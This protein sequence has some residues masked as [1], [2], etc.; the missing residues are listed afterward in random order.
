MSANNF[1]YPDGYIYGKGCIDPNEKSLASLKLG[2]CLE[3]I[4]GKEGRVLEIGCGGGKFI[5]S[6]KKLR[7]ELKIFGCDIYLNII[8]ENIKYGDGLK[9]SIADGMSLPF[10]NNS[11]DVVLIFDVLEHLSDVSMAVKEVNR[12][13]KDSGT[14]HFYVPCENNRS[15]IYRWLGRNLKKYHG[16][17][18]QAL[19]Y[20]DV[21]DV[22]SRN[23]FEVVK[24]RHSDYFFAQA[25]DFM[26]FVCLNTFKNKSLLW[27]AHG[28]L[29]EK[30][31]NKMLFNALVHLKKVISFVSY[32]ESKILKCKFG[33]MG[34]HITCRKK[35]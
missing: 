5:R 26:F 16:G 32:Y 35:K 21:V 3:G 6:L 10:R 19:K 27:S 34:L 24:A 17:H 8:R 9:Y 20:S 1:N 29:R 30:N 15:S 28:E 18:I 14:A 25:C 7:P 31:D 4:K 33:S 13:L 12:V 22:C 2:N 23:N 11:F